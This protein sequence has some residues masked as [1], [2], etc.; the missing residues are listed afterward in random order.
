MESENFNSNEV[1]NCNDSGI[2]MNYYQNLLDSIKDQLGCQNTPEMNHLIWSQFLITLS[3]LLSTQTLN[4]NE[5]NN[6]F[7]IQD[8]SM[9]NDLRTNMNGNKS[10]D[11]NSRKFPCSRCGKNFKRASTLHTHLMIH[12]N[13]RPYE[14]PFEN[15]EKR[16]HQ[17]S[18]MK[19]HCYTHTGEK[20]YQ[21][22]FCQKCFSQSSNL[23]T[24]QRKHTN[25][26]PFLCKL[27]GFRFQRK[28]ELKRHQ[29]VENIM[30][31]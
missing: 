7:T 28:N 11:D 23:I 17:K 26:Q 1:N 4:L 6:N 5:T 16:F 20:P 18:D 21:C 19:K 31:K 2:M 13:I 30:L 27:C 24:H 3:A 8:T 9:S 25:F 12:S 14:C 29:Q 22:M 15:C 10:S